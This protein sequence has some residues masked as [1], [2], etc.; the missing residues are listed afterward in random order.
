M[1]S[2]YKQTSQS[3]ML[4]YKLG[5]KQLGW[6]TQRWK[7]MGEWCDNRTNKMLEVWGLLTI[8]LKYSVMEDAGVS[9]LPASMEELENSEV[10]QTGLKG[11]NFF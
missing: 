4:M 10:R 7:M 1:L 3:Q 8:P 11:I 6:L 5:P 2:L 9:V